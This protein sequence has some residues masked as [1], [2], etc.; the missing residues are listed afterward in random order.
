MYPKPKL[1]W[2]VYKAYLNNDW[3]YIFDYLLGKDLPISEAQQ[4]GIKIHKE[5]EERGLA[6]CPS[7][8]KLPNIS[9]GRYEEVVLKEFPT[10]FIVGKIDCLTNTDVLDWKTGGMSGYEAQLQLY[11]Y[12]AEKN[13]AYLVSVNDEREVGRVYQYRAWR[14]IEEYWSVRFDQF[15]LDIDSHLEEMF[16]YSTEGFYSYDVLNAQARLH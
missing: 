11:M 2:T 13:N 14:D 4:R 1:S 7:L 15:V 3:A 12:L 16:M 6:D 8:S 5:I 10:H 9:T